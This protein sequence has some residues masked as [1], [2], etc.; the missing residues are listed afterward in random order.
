M[1]VCVIQPPYSTDYLKSDEYFKVECD[2]LDKCD[3]SMDIIVMPENCDIPCLA[4]T[5]EQH[6]AVVEKYNQPLLNKAKE[7]AVRCNSIV[8]INVRYKAENGYRNTTYAIDRKG[9]IA[10]M[11]FKQHLVP[12]EINTLKLDYSYGAE[13]DEP[14]VIE[15][16]GIRFGF[17]TCYDFYFYEAFAKMARKNLDVIIGCSH[18]RSDTHEA[19]ATITKFLAYNTNTYVLRSS[20]SMGEDS[21]T[22]GASMVVA[23]DGTILANMYSRV[24]METVDIDINKKYYKP[25]GY[26]NP[27]AAHYEYI[28]N[29]RRPWQ[30]RISGSSVVLN[31]K[32]MPYPRVCAHRG[33]NTIAPENSMPAFGA[34]IAMGAEEIEFD[35]WETKDGEVVSL[36]DP[37]LDRVSDG[38]G[39][40]YDYAY[41]EL[42]KFDFGYKHGEKFKGIKILK[43]EEILK[44]YACRVIM[45]IHIKTIDNNCTL[46][47]EYINKIVSLINKYDCADYVYFTTGNDN[48]LAQLKEIA[49]QICRCCGGGD[50]PWDM[51]ERA[52]KYDCKKIQLFK[53]YFN[54]EMIDKA[55]AN[56][57]KC[58]VF[59]SDDAEETKKFISMG[60]DCILTNDYNLISQAVER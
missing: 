45:N 19:L 30:Y 50:A 41:D 59:W 57:I 8:F 5:K 22:G 47:D 24:G 16:E 13:Y 9:N 4:K 55:H 6:D 29:G 58:N 12:S 27:Y 32:Q 42:L 56:G 40:V 46:P 1:K 2:L 26:G 3:K 60:I 23:P 34:A 38:V 28:E 10:G 21:P 35:L 43:F 48:L 52:I 54:Q 17:L 51:V 44:K 18:Q 14:T 39:N 11:Y 31:D 49:P 7:T 53:P 33:F 15:I 37:T 25:A 36:H 20:V